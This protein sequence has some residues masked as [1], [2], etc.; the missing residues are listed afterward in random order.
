MVGDKC[1]KKVMLIYPP[2]TQPVHSKKRCLVPLG[3]MYIAGYLREHNI[4]VRVLDCVI[5]GYDNEVIN[6]DRKTFGLKEESIRKQIS[7]YN[8]DFV[9]VS[10]L[11]TEQRHNAYMVCEVAKSVNSDIHTVMGGCHPS[12]LP[13]EVLKHKEVDSVVVG[14]GELSMLKIVNGE[15]S[16]K[17]VSELLDINSIPLP[18]RD[19]VPMKKYIDINMPENTFSP[20]NKVTQM[21]SSRG[22]PF[23]CY[24]CSTTKFHGGW[25][26]RTAESV[27]SELQMLK[28]K[29]GVEEVNIIDENFVADRE[30][31]VEIMNGIKKIGIAWSNPGGIWVQGLDNDLLDLMKEAGCYQLTFAIETTNENVLHKVIR[32]PLKLEIVEPLVKHCRKIGIDTHAFFICGFPEQTKQDMINDFEYAKRIKLD[33]AS[34]HIISPFPGS[35]L[36]DDYRDKIDLENIG[37]TRVS[38]EHPEMTREELEKMVN[39]FNVK[40]NKSLLWRRPIKYFKKYWGTAIRRYSL[41]ELPNLFRRQ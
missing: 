37:Y 29:Y 33:S 20:Y 25:R 31:T 38:I 30:R 26:G 39:E 23:N 28:D 16:G 13:D 15:D 5:E 34:F 3:I 32:K 21:L 8:P 2:F 6:G 36:F 19:L 40:F 35:D 24:F 1:L 11:M 41:K 27:I 14:E 18:A 22:C 4:D 9:G 12:A 17:V 7:D 10:C